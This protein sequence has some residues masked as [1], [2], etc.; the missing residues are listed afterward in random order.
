MME[1]GY[2]ENGNLSFDGTNDYV[3]GSAYQSLDASITNEITISAW[4]KVN[5]FTNGNFSW[6]Q[7]F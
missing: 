1:V 7:W 5:D 2:P 6:R 3:V 4:V